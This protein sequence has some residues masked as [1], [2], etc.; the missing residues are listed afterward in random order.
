MPI[1]GAS[2]RVLVTAG[3]TWEF[4]DD[5]RFISSPSTG[6]MGFAVAEAFAAAG[7][8]VDLVTGPTHLEPP[9]KV[10]CVRV[11]SAVEM[12]RAVME[13]LE[14]ADAVVMTA[15]VGD[16]RVS[17]RFKG[18]RKRVGGKWLLEL[19]E[20]PD[21]LREIG[22]N[23]GGRI[24]VGFAVESDSP[25]KGAL[26]KLRKKNLDFIVLNA[27]SAFGADVT[28][29]DIIDKNERTTELRQVAKREVAAQILR[30]VE[31]LRKTRQ[32]GGG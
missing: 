23:K 1:G 17:E 19:V 13:R 22:Q 16:Y 20:N 5:V 14:A 24:L 3:P 9:P 7:H 25:R 8:A 6:R 31:D 12:H 27:P 11:K 18:K 15:A 30:L 26:E 10:A 32:S 21:I 4:I 29:V 2:V 28:S